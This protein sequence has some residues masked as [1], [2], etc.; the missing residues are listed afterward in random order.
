MKIGFHFFDKNMQYSSYKAVTIAF[1]LP[2][3][4]R[5]FSIKSGK[6]K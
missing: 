2:F 1:K 6:K 4:H 3:L 5:V